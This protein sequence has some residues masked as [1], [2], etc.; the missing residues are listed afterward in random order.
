[1]TYSELFNV[2]HMESDDTHYVRFGRKVCLD[3]VT[4]R[5]P[6]TECNLD[7]ITI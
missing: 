5:L 3:L 4:W 2:V 6:Q 1:M 7:V